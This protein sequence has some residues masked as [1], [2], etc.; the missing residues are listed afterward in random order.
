VETVYMLLLVHDFSRYMWVSLLSSKDQVAL[1][2]QRI[3][4][5]AERKSGNILCAHRTDR[6]ESTVAQFSQYCV[7]PRIH[8]ELTA[9][10]SPQQNGVVERRNQ[11]VLA[12]AR[13][14]MKAQESQVCF[15]GRQ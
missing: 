9:P 6:G 1:A 2:I 11:T 14:M 15:G 10:Y 5:A 13:C 8:R 3:Q 4:A 12:A 7:E